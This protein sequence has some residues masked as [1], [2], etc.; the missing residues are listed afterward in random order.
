VVCTKVLPRVGADQVDK[1]GTI[2]KQREVGMHGRIS[3][4]SLAFK[5]CWQ[6]YQLNRRNK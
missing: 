5:D 4:A 1:L 6:G 3:Q 2:L